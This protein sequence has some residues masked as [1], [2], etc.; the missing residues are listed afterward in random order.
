[1]IRSVVRRTLLLATLLALLAVPATAPAAA[2]PR[3]VSLDRGW[4]FGVDGQAAKP[5]AVPHVMQATT[6]PATFNGTTGTYRLRFTAPATPRGFGWGLRFEQVRRVA[7][8]VLNG[9]TI[10][11]HQ[12]PYTPFTLP[13]STLRPG[14]NA[15]VVHVDNRKGPEPREGWW[16]WG[17]ITRP[18]TLVP[19]GPI[20]LR[21]AGL[22][23]RVACD[24]RGRCADGQFLLD[25]EL[26]NRSGTK[27]RPWVT[28]ALRAPDGRVAG[29]ARIAGPLL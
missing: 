12:D 18:V 6:T 10:G 5:I 27:T 11:V 28:V 8:V 7:R 17:G 14:A 24:R 1:M 9:K 13:A 4:T 16:N 2:P 26:V 22:M 15:L 21:D 3:A 23:P 25:G 20:V 29:R 19:L